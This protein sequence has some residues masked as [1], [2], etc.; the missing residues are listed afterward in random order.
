MSVVPLRPEIM[1]PDTLRETT[2]PDGR[3]GGRSGR[4]SEAGAAAGRAGRA[5][6]LAGLR[7]RIARLER[8]GAAGLPALGFGLA[9]LDAALP[10]GG[11]APAALHEFAGAA[12]ALAVAAAL[13]ARRLAQGAGGPVLWCPARPG[14]YP[15][16]LQAFGLGPERLILAWAGERR[17]R[18]WALEEGLASGRTAL[19]VGE[20]GR[21]E[22]AASRR[23]QLAAERGATPALLLTG[24]AGPGAASAAA[25]RWRVEGAASAPTAGWRGVGASRFRLALSRCRGGRPGAWLIEWD[26][27][28]HTFALAA[29]LGE[30][31]A[32]ARL[33]RA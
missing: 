2:R 8:P 6:L 31:A 10:A 28:T 4:G 18:L 9:A 19:V 26:D 21:L 15:P 29:E 16:G 3:S 11:L 13:A 20:V 32:P 24:A 27:A 25:T 23:L 12:P 30:R 14:L 7:R 33:A 17:R 1:P 22:L 5:A